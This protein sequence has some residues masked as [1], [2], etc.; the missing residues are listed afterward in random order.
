MKCEIK[1]FSDG[2]LFFNCPECDIVLVCDEKMVAEIW[3]NH[4]GNSICPDCN[5]SFNMPSVNEVDALKPEALKSSKKSFWQYPLLWLFISMSLLT[6]AVIGPGI[7]ERVESPSFYLVWIGGILLIGFV[8]AL[9][10]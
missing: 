6:F 4:L 5:A 8:S 2:V 10:I 1:S 9:F 3:S 7:S